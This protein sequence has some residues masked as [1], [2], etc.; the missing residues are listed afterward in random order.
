MENIKYLICPKGHWG[1]FD[2]EDKYCKDCG[3]SLISKC[4][5][6][7][8]PIKYTE[9]KYCVHCGKPFLKKKKTMLDVTG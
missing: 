3:D 1:S 6:C 7:E 4:S 9:I 8:K 5:N 2:K